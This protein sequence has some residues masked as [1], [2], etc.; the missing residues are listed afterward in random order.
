MLTVKNDSN[1]FLAVKVCGSTESAYTCPT[2]GFLIPGRV[3]DFELSE[4]ELKHENLRVV[5]S[6]NDGS[7]QYENIF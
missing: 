6:S 1:R 3:K 7:I 2:K 5:V 4:E